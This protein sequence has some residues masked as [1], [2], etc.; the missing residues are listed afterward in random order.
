MFGLTQLAKGSINEVIP[1][2]TAVT[3]TSVAQ[4]A[5]GHNAMIVHADITGVGAWTIKVQGAEKFNG[6]YKDMFDANGNSMS[7]GSISVDRCQ[8]FVGI[9]EN[10]KIV[11]TENTDGATIA[12]QVE[13]FTV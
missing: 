12:V 9:P 2:L 10:F 11:A 3:T 4:K 13:L 7:T 5:K 1:A 6:T 8:L